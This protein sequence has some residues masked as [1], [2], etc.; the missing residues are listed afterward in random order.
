MGRF[1][2]GGLMANNPTLD[3]LTEIH[4][5]NMGQGEYARFPNLQP[6][7]IGVDHGQ[8]QVFCLRICRKEI[9]CFPRVMAAI[10]LLSSVPILFSALASGDSSTRRLGTV[11]SFGTGRP[12]IVPVKTVDVF[13]P[14]S[15]F[16]LETAKAMLGAKNLGTLL[17]E[18]ATSA[19]G[20]WFTSGSHL[21]LSVFA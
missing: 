5:F 6:M 19:D 2:D 20:R 12:P 10:L 1:L 7:P 14:E 13:M 9:F 18:Q 4:K 17:V 8:A 3:A 16:S 15:M 11:V 21:L